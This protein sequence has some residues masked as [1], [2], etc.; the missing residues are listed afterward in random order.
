MASIRIVRAEKYLCAACGEAWPGNA[1]V[2]IISGAAAKQATGV[3]ND[4]GEK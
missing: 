2:T 3:K 1:S 4:G